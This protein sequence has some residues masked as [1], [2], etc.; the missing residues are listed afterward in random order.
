MDAYVYVL[1]TATAKRRLTYVGWTDDVARRLAQHNAG[2][3]ALDA[4]ARLG[5]AAF[6]TVCDQT[7]SHEPRM[8]FK[9]RPQIQKTIGADAVRCPLTARGP[10]VQAMAR[11]MK[12]P[13]R[14]SAALAL[15]N[16]PA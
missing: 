9:A 8:V 7:R 13:A 2:K 10:Y 16:N 1:G 11:A 12:L 5:A 14:R 4:R 15:G 6:G 3:R